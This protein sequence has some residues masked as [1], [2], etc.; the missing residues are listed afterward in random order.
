MLYDVARSKQGLLIGV[1]TIIRHE[2]EW[3]GGG[4][5]LEGVGAE[6]GLRLDRRT[7]EHRGGL[8]GYWEI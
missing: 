6:G 1:S 4:G 5:F 7:P 2:L 8:V 3:G